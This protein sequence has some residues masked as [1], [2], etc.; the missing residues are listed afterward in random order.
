MEMHVKSLEPCSAAADK[1]KKAIYFIASVLTL[2]EQ[3]YLIQT[4]GLECSNT[5]QAH[6]GGGKT[7]KAVIFRFLYNYLASSIFFSSRL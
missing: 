2:L 3:N 6:F 7:V 5:S 4:R 1:S